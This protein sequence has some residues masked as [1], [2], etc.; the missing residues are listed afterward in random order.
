[1]RFVYYIVASLLMASTVV[2]AQDNK[3][4]KTEIDYKDQPVK[5]DGKYLIT[6]TVMPKET[7]YSIS[8]RYNVTVEDLVTLNPTLASG[9]KANSIIIVKI[10]DELPSNNGERVTEGKPVVK[11]EE[12]N[13]HDER[14]AVAYNNNESS[15]QAERKTS[16]NADDA[17]WNEFYGATA[18]ESAPVKVDLVRMGLIL[19]IHASDTLRFNRNYYDFYA[20]ALIAAKELK[21]ND[22]NLVLNLYDQFDYSSMAA[23]ENTKDFIDN[24]IIVGP[25]KKQ[26]I[27]EVLPFAA[28]RGIVIVSP[29]DQSSEAFV[30]S[31]DN[32]IQVPPSDRLHSK[33]L[34]ESLTEEYSHNHS[35][36][37]LLIH[38]RSGKDVAEV[39]EAI[40]MMDSLNIPY[41]SLAYGILEGR[42]ILTKI[43]SFLDKEAEQNIV[44]VPSNNEAFVSD[45]L[46]NLSLSM[47]QS[48]K[49]TLFGLPK[50]RNFETINVEL[51]HQMNL[52]LSLPYFVNYDSEEV[53]SFIMQFRALFNGEPS[54]F[55]FQG[56][57]IVKYFSN[58][59]Y[60]GG[61]KKFLK[62]LPKAK[63]LQVDFDFSRK[64]KGMENIAM[65]NIIYRPDFSIEVR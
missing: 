19:P 32:F 49:V 25:V 10:L 9:L 28:K 37:V 53:K 54:P 60:S 57:D 23:M 47:K 1:M 3:Q 55:A 65:R 22:K 12:G 20:G 33:Y 5:V 26:A 4:I 62:Y 51:F 17:F 45:V 44:I 52:H 34:Y 40:K 59:I 14:K 2:Q 8:K 39:G 43:N 41:N 64:G 24:D 7:L 27:A 16:N 29:M 6:H 15:R 46:R 36:K 42:G 48:Y 63:M 56:Y 21:E 18:Q 50:W 30:E 13:K 38:E 61:T 35:R 31:Y 11:R 58:A